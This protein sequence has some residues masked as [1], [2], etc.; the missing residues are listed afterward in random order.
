M[1]LWYIF[2]LKHQRDHSCAEGGKGRNTKY[3]EKDED[4][5]VQCILLKIKT[6]RGICHLI[7]AQ[8][9]EDFHSKPADRQGPRAPDNCG[10]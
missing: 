7:Q 10:D 2:G 8:R 5:L 6:D 1:L 9:E 3:S 4:T